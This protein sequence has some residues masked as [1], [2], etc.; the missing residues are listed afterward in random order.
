MEEVLDAVEDIGNL[1]GRCAIYEAL[2]LT[3]QTTTARC[4]RVIID[5]YSAILVYLFHAK[6]YYDKNTTGTWGGYNKIPQLII[7]VRIFAGTFDTALKPLLDDVRNKK[8][9]VLEVTAVAEVE[10]RLILFVTIDLAVN[11]N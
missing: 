3:S 10:C 9:I 5:L 8:A 1:I 6:Q 2:Y 4:Q 7:V 11:S